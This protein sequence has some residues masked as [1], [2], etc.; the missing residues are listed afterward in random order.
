MTDYTQ[1]PQKQTLENE[2]QGCITEETIEITKGI[3]E[4]LKE[5]PSTQL[6]KFFGEVKRIQMN[7]RVEPN[8]YNESQLILLKPKLAYAVGRNKKL[9]E[10]KVLQDCLNVSIDAVTNATDKKKAFAN[11]VSFFE[12]VVAYHKINAKD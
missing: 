3:G 11:F 12:A 4:E 7:G 2:I 1:N 5:V 10:L 9:K 8:G 6:R